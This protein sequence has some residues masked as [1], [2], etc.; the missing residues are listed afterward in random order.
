MSFCDDSQTS[1][2]ALI[3]PQVDLQFR[4]TSHP[5]ASFPAPFLSLCPSPELLN[6]P[7]VYYLHNLVALNPYLRHIF[8]SSVIAFSY[9]YPAVPEAP[10]GPKLKTTDAIREVANDI[11]DDEKDGW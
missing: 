5:E 9:T 11:M 6:F 2:R 4:H 1:L 3:L 7:Q 8:P 10:G